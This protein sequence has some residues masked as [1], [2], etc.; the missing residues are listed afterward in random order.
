MAKR[1]SK[2]RSTTD[3]ILDTGLRRY[4]E[5]KTTFL[6]CRHSSESWNPVFK[7]RIFSV[8]DYLARIT[9]QLKAEA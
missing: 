3:W 5:T 9:E 1:H 4:D 2:E 7:V 8:R 6:H